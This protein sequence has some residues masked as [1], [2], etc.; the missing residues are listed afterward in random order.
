MLLKIKSSLFNYFYLNQEI[1]CGQKWE[2]ELKRIF[3]QE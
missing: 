1:F 2:D 3:E